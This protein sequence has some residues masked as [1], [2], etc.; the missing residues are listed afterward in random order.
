MMVFPAA[1]PARAGGGIPNGLGG[2]NLQGG[3]GYSPRRPTGATA[4]AMILRR[5]LDPQLQIV[6]AA[7]LFGGL[8]VFGTEG[9]TPAG[10]LVA[11]AVRN[12]RTGVAPAPARPSFET[13]LLESTPERI[14]FRIRFDPPAWHVEEVAGTTTRYPVWRGLSPLGSPEQP[15]I[16][17]AVV[18]IALPP[19][20]RVRVE[21]E[22]GNGGRAAGVTFPLVPRPPKEDAPFG[23]L[24]IRPPRAGVKQIPL[25]HAEILKL[26]VERGLRT[27]LLAVRPVRRAEDGSRDVYWV[28]SLDVTLDIAGGTVAKSPGNTRP[29]RPD[30]QATALWNASLLNPE[31]VPGFLSSPAQAAS[32]PTVWFDDGAGWLKI[33]VAQNGI[34][35]L[36]R[37]AL[38]QAGVPVGTIDPRT[39]RL[40]CGPLVPELAWTTLGWRDTVTAGGDTTRASRWYHVSERPG[41]TTGFG[42]PGGMEE[43]DLWVDGESDGK[44]DAA[45]RVVFYGLGPDNYRDRFGLPPGGEDYFQNPYSD[46]TVY[47]LTWEGTFPGSAQRMTTLDVS[48]GPG[49]P[50]TE[51]AARVHTEQNTIYAPSLF[52]GGLRWETWFWD[53]LSSQATLFRALVTLPAAVPGST[54]SGRARLW[55]A[56]APEGTGDD[57]LHHVQLDVNS[58]SQGTTQWGGTTTYLTLSPQ[59]VAVLSAPVANPSRFEFR[60]PSL[61]PG[62]LDIQ[63]LA[64]IDVN[65]RRT[66]SLGSQPGEL[67]IEPGASGRVIQMAQVP[68]G[69]LDVFDVT[70]FRHP[71]RLLGAA[72]AASVSG[73]DLALNDPE[74]A[75]IAVAS[76]SAPQTPR[77]VELD[78][79]AGSWLRD[80]SE[81]LD[82]VII[83]NDAF[84]TEGER[85]AERR[86]TAIPFIA[87]PHVRVVRVSDVMD[88]FAWGMWD[89]IAL[90]YFLEYVYRYYGGAGVTPLSYALFL[91][92]HTYDFRNYLGTG[93]PDFVPSWEDNRE[94]LDF[95]D[96]GSV[97]YVSDDPLVQFDGPDDPFLDVAIGRIPAGSTAA[98]QAIIEGKILRSEESPVFG[99]WRAR[100]ILA[101]DD[102]CQLGSPDPVVPDFPSVAED[103]DQRLP[104]AFDRAKVYLTEYGTACSISSKPQASDDFIALWNSGAWLVNYVGHGTETFYADERLL[105]ATDIPSLTNAD[106]LPLLIATA[107]KAAKFNLPGQ[108]SITESIAMSPQGGALAA[109]GSVSN[110]TFSDVA[111]ALNQNFVSRL[112]LPDLGCPACP[113][114]P[115]PAGLAFREAK[116]ATFG[117]TKKYVFFGD[118]AGLPPAAHLGGLSLAGPDSLARGGLAPLTARLLFDF[119]VP[120]VPATPADWLL[121]IRAEDATQ[122]RPLGYRLPGDLMFRGD[123]RFAADSVAAAFTVPIAARE[124]PDA[125]VRGYAWDGSTDVLAA[126]TPVRIAGAV[127]PSLDTQGPI[128]T[129]N[130][131]PSEMVIG[132]TLAAVIEDPSGV[133]LVTS[134]QPALMLIVLDD[135]QAEVTRVPL[136]DYFQYDLGSHVRGTARFPIPQV[137]ANGGYTLR[138]TAA[139]NFGNPASASTPVHVSSGATGVS[140][141]EVYAYPNPLTTDTDVVFTLDRDVQVTLR[142]FSVSGR[143]VQ[144]ATVLGAPGRNGYHWDGRDQAG[145]QVANGVYLLQLS[146]QGNSGDPVKHLERLVVLR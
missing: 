115:V 51:S 98:A 6:A 126:L 60:V 61:A 42:E 35:T 118:P 20:G 17:A 112:F 18:R 71:R 27:A 2:W 139:D 140:I 43:V 119:V 120:P 28:E 12:I 99:S 95:I 55:G 128:I 74:R 45:D 44:I 123:F 102:I 4:L 59:D 3:R 48:P 15:A 47:W 8:A 135:Q 141:S 37:D 9:S 77:S 67:E 81:G 41:F 87:S 40:F 49:T 104:P 58:T 110:Q 101:A 26:G 66:L 33:H 34:Y 93:I 78:D 143:L 116:G 146:A 89:P 107:S 72:S 113:P 129:F 38:A 57:A 91:G 144:K 75:V 136:T 79:V 65:Y 121:E 76:R 94:D 145:D 92:D 117:D 10:K 21:E 56:N 62:R 24:A 70:S 11:P 7:M 73:I 69:T 16:D 86:R 84:V 46:Y 132:Q 36:T 90:R 50:I 131:H 63:Y 5:K 111:F 80:T 14:R 130:T 133:L 127:D 32:I 1:H 19:R 30:L 124:G 53:I 39:F 125:R 100:I 105:S 64:W 85:L 137:P 22:P 31:S 114:A 13:E 103:I 25:H 83:A 88:E 82:E 54:I 134:G 109:T 138:V 29:N 122:Q 23:G 142:I 108:S 52:Q 68:A 96:T 97:Q 106:R